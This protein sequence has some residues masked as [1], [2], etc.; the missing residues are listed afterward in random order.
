MFLIL[1]R[2]SGKKDTF[3]SRKKLP[4][5]KPCKLQIQESISEVRPVDWM[6]KLQKKMLVDIINVQDPIAF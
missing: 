4:L 6:M 1:G 5:P 2:I 3:N